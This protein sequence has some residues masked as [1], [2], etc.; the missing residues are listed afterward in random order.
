MVSARCDGNVW[1]F[2]RIWLGFAVRQPKLGQAQYLAASVVKFQP[3]AAGA[4]IIQCT[5]S[6]RGEQLVDPQGMRWNQRLGFSM[7]RERKSE[8]QEK[9]DFWEH[10]SDL[11]TANLAEFRHSSKSNPPLGQVTSP[12]Q[13]KLLCKY[14]L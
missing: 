8:K 2:P 14:E 12:Q 11:W 9:W 4:L 6:V 3:V 5:T 7:G 10:K 1:Q 13:E